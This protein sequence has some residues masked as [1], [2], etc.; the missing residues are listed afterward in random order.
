MLL[1]VL[2]NR[3]VGCSVR[4]GVSVESLS[5][6]KG[7]LERP[8]GTREKNQVVPVDHDIR[9][10]QNGVGEEAQLE[11]SLGLLVQRAGVL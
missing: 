8:R 7:T 2:T 9:R 11:R 5:Q 10:L 3:N 4:S 1:L 6:S